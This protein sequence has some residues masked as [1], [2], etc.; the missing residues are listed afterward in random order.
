MKPNILTGAA[1]VGAAVFG[2]LAIS[3][4]SAQ[5]GKPPVSADRKAIEA[6]V[7]DVIRENPEIVIEAL[8]AYSERQ[9][10]DAASA[11]MPM[12]LAEETG[13]VAGKNP[14]AA[15]VVVVELFDYHCGFCKRA[16][17]LVQDLARND[18]AVKVV[19][20]DLPLLR[21]ES[22]V[23][24]RYA[25]AARE[26]GK[27]LDYHFALMAQSGVLTEERLK[28]VAAKTGLDVKKLEA[29]SKAAKLETAL[30]GNFEAA[31]QMRLDGTPSFI[32]TSLNGE[33]LRVI[34][35]LDEK[36]VRAAIAEAKKAKSAG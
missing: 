15:T 36:S 34:P 32:V 28:E 1:L 27:Y 8:N 29:D 10:A 24:A 33:F 3:V 31:E 21:K 4:V 11:A 25:L 5:P 35:G 19:L 20:R 6:I 16:T 13:F 26:Q 17:G 12:L 22:D 2:A 7:R 9:S 18:A 14:A 23:A 30:R